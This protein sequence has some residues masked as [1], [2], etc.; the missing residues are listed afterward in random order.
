MS[1]DP[2]LAAIRRRSEQSARAEQSDPE[3]RAQRGPGAASD[4]DLLRSAMVEGAVQVAIRRG[5]FDGLPGAGKPIPGL[6]GP[7]DPDW[8]IR[9]KIQTEQL[10]GLGPAA[11]TLRVEDAELDDHLDQIARESEVRDRLEDFNRR[12]IDARRQL[13]GGPPVITATR[14]IDSEVAA[15]RERRTRRLASAQE[16]HDATQDDARPMRRRLFRRRDRR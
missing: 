7:H 1:E 10:H 14:D 8:W 16:E 2:R 12:V 6:D 13:E 9:R 11:L 4:G 15:W 5:D 3:D